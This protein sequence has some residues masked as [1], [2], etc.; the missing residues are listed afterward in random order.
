[1]FLSGVLGRLTGDQSGTIDHDDMVKAVQ[2]KTHTVVDVREVR[3]FQSG[4]I[5]GAINVPLSAFNPAKIP[6]GKPVIVFCATG[7]R[8]GMA[9]QIL[10]SAGH[11]DVVNYRPG[12]SGWRLQGQPLV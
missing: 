8:S 2:N 4:T 3:E 5:K 11:S 1:M 12:V 10:K 6:S 9:Q 7:G